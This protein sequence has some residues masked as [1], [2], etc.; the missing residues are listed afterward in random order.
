MIKTK[1]YLTPFIIFFII[2]FFTSFLVGQYPIT[3]TQVCKILLSRVLPLKRAW[4]SVSETV[5]FNIRLPRILMAILVGGGLSLSGLVYQ[6]LF[7]NPLVSPDVLG[8]TN[9]ASF[10][11]SVALLLNFSYLGI[12]FTSFF[13]GLLCVILVLLISSKIRSNKMLSLILSGIMI[14]SLFSSL[15]SFVKLVADTDNTLPAITYFLMGSLSSV[16]RTDL[17]F[18]SILIIIPTIIISFISYQLNLLTQG[19]DEARSMGVNTRLIR[20]IAILCS[21]VI[22]SVCV[23]TSGVIGWVGLV[24]P[25]FT[26]MLIGCDYKKTIKASLLLGASFLLLVDTFARGLTTF[27]VPLGILTSFIGAPFFLYLIW[28]EGKKL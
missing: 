5:V 22:T 7:Q 26:R 25:H 9:G 12:T 3:P 1:H 21:T 24:I 10:G 16:R 20:T 27:E 23:A 13:F 14:S 6:G 17:L 2:M 19:E 4:S 15:T 18:T 11:L 8:T 28:R